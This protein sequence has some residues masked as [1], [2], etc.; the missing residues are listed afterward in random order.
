M[1]FHLI[2]ASNALQGTN[3]LDTWK[4]QVIKEDNGNG[5]EGKGNN[6]KR[7]YKIVVNQQV[8]GL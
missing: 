4:S 7:N 1:G 6:G 3:Y 8:A 2:G 5:M